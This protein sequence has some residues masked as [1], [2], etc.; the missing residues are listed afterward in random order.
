MFMLDYAVNSGSVRNNFKG[1]IDSVINKA[2]KVVNRHG[3][4]F[5]AINVQHIAPL[6]QGYS[7][8]ANFELDDDGMYISSFDEIPDLLGYGYT[9]EESLQELVKDLIEYAHDYLFESFTL[10]I[11]APN[12][13]AHF[14]YVLKVMTKDTVADVLE[15]IN[16]EH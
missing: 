1:F 9:K 14:P 4:H 3:D 7:L 11:N 13:T 16:V 10:Y 6:V 5:L 12:R 15:F 2:P 8:T